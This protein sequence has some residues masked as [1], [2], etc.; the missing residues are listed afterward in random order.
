MTKRKS[1]KTS[2]AYVYRAIYPDDFVDGYLAKVIRRHHRL[3]EVFQLKDFDG[4]HDA[5]MRAAAAKA[6]AFARIHPRLTRREIAELPHPKKDGDLPPGV[7]RATTIVKGYPY[8]FYEAEWSPRPN[9]QVKRKF[10]V[11]RWGDEGAKAL[12]IEARKKGLQQME[13]P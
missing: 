6:A 5:C 11:N 2:F 8:D 9:H 13:R 7:R 12:A 1:H 4:N 10:S 3:H